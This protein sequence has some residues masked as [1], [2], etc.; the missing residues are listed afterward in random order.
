MSPRQACNLYDERHLPHLSMIVVQRCNS[1][2]SQ[3]PL[4]TV[5]MLQA[6]SVFCNPNQLYRYLGNRSIRPT[7][8]II[9]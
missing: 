4:P 1:S 6:K 5:Q 9:I 3:I 8:A 2:T 7:H